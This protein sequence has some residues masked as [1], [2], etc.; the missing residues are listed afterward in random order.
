MS[1]REVATRDMRRREFIKAVEGAA[2]WP[3][4]AH[5]E[6]RAIPSV[7]YHNSALLVRQSGIFAV[8]ARAK[9]TNRGD[10]V[11]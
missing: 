5:T 7:G 9:L 8:V 11:P 6:E 4:A 10:A 2:V 3:A 1:A